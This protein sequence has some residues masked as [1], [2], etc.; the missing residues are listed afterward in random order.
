MMPEDDP[1]AGNRETR[2]IKKRN[3][4]TLWETEKVKIGVA[5]DR[6]YH[7][8]SGRNRTRKERKK[9]EPLPLRSKMVAKAPKPQT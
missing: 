4:R 7:P 1:V 2:L 6:I 3:D 8:K 9:V 5:S